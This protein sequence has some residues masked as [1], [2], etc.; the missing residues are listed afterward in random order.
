MCRYLSDLLQHHEPTR[1]LH[2]SSSHQLSVPHHNL[3]FWYHVFR[4]AAPR[5]WSSLPVSNRE[6]KSLPTFINS[7]KD[8]LFS[9]NPSPLSCPS[10]LEYLP[11]RSRILLRTLMLYEPCTYLL[12]YFVICTKINTILHNINIYLSKMSIKVKPF[13]QSH[14]LYQIAENSHDIYLIWIYVFHVYPI[15]QQMQNI[16]AKMKCYHWTRSLVTSGIINK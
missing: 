12:T 1:S 5:V 3:T 7:S 2:S 14:Q 10:C 13:L 6:T 4:F 11:P 9:V 15:T 8:I 16:K